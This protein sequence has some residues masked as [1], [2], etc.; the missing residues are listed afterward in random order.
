MYS[1]LLRSFD[2]APNT[3]NSW[4]WAPHLFLPSSAVP[5]LA[6]ARKTPTAEITQNPRKLSAG[7]GKS[8]GIRTK[9]WAAWQPTQPS[10]KPAWDRTARAWPAAGVCRRTPY[11][12][13]WLSVF[14]LSTITV[15]A[16]VGTTV[17]ATVD[18]TVHAVVDTAVTI[19]F[20]NTVRAERS[21][22]RHRMTPIGVLPIVSPSDSA[23]T[24]PSPASAWAAVT[25]GIV[26]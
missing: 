6:R 14:L 22:D 25:G 16:P 4:A 12:A 8:S 2:D 11:S 9:A 18:T 7:L 5:E 13:P 20:S 15:T 10:T 17:D 21:E 1:L 23:L 3:T 19:V 24:T 26:R